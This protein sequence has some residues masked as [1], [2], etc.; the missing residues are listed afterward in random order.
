MQDWELA[1]PAF[2]DHTPAPSGYIAW[3]EWAKKMGRT[4]R[5]IK[6]TGCK[7]YAI[8]VPKQRRAKRIMRHGH[9]SL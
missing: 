9:E 2:H 1:C 8:W 5:P 7:R 4:H 6:C 3:H